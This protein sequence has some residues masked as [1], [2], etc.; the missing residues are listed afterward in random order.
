MR[1]ILILA[2]ALLMFKSMAQEKVVFLD[3]KEK[4]V[5]N[6]G[7]ATYANV[8][9]KTDSGFL[10][11]RLLL[12]SR[13]VVESALYADSLC[14]FH[15]GHFRLYHSN[16]LLKTDGNYVDGRKNGIWLSYHSNGMI[17]D[18]ALYTDNQLAGIQKSW[19][20]NGYL[21]DSSNG[22]SGNRV[23]VSW[24]DDGALASTGRYV[25]D[26][27]R[28]GKWVFYNQ[29]GVKSASVIYNRGKA[30][31]ID[32]IATDG[33]IQSHAYADSFTIAADFPGGINN[34]MK[35]FN[36]KIYFPENIELVNT[37]ITTVV[38]QFCVN[39]KGEVQDVELLV[40][41]HPAFDRIVLDIVKKS[42]RWNPARIANR[43]YPYYHTQ[44]IH[45]KQSY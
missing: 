12:S 40:P 27:L 31:T 17:A 14:L 6:A 1:S 32:F 45:F 11:Q 34:W 19:H 22:Y 8:I 5:P 25:E 2:C 24:F 10:K 26:S 18:S 7:L 13:I 4:P 3:H 43:P 33:S 36:S 42:P 29:E 37:D 20:R 28:H 39:T 9:S 41:F 35:Y 15:K 38:V 44:E 21:A 16:G 23:A 30:T